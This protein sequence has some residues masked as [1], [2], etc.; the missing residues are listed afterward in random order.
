MIFDWFKKKQKTCLG[1]DLGASG[2]KVVELTRKEKDRISLANYVI[3]QTKLE[4]NFSIAKLGPDDVAALLQNILDRAGIKTRQAVVSLSVGET[5][6][7]I[8][9]MPAMSEEELTKAIPYHARK[10][11]PIPIEEVVLDW[12]VVG[13][14]IQTDSALAETNSV[15][16]PAPEEGGQPKQETSEAPPAAGAKMLQVLI[17]AVPQEVI[18]KIAQIA[19]KTELKVLAVEQEA[20]S[21]IRSLVGRDESGYLIIDLGQENVDLIIMDKA[22]IRL[23][24]TF[25]KNKSL[26][27]I[28]EASKIIN[29][30][31]TRYNRKIG[32]I[33]LIGGWVTQF[34]W[35]ETFGGKFNIPVGLGDPF[36]R[37]A[38]DP[39]LDTA[40]KEIGPFMAVAVGGAMREI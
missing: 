16:P 25:E 35:A 5:F 31:Q 29:S 11:V 33:I 18:R 32:R 22:S 19:K 1:I 26:D 28:S 37:I 36:A 24:Y 23:S 6:S 15:A 9:N 20:F 38:H 21:I 2:I 8:I 27:L 34:N 3:A 12:S 13:E 10:Y 7:T 14:Y 4:S 40:L 39:K 30:Y 17:V